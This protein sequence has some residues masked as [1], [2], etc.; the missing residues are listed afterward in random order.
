VNRLRDGFHTR[1]EQ[2][3]TCAEKQPLFAPARQASPHA[4]GSYFLKHND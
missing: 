1:H 4:S 2:L 3:I